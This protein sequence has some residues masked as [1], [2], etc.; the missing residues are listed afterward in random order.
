M[1]EW[2]VLLPLVV[3]D[4]VL[5][6]IDAVGPTGELEHCRRH[7]GSAGSVASGSSAGW[8]HRVTAG[9]SGRNSLHALCDVRLC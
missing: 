9:L 4:P 3:S 6:S 7:D 1:A 5:P 8:Q 2:V